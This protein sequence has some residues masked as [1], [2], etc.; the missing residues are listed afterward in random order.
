AVKNALGAYTGTDKLCYLDDADFWR[1]FGRHSI[2]MIFPNHNPGILCRVGSS[3][4]PGK[5]IIDN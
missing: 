4:C 5:L 3:G 1:F 2:Y